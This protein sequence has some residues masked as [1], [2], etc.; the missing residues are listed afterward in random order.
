M[1][2]ALQAALKIL[3]AALQHPLVQEAGKEA[4]RAATVAVVRH[5]QNRT[6]STRTVQHIH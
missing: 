1:A 2:T 3:I 5:I 4:L 6:R